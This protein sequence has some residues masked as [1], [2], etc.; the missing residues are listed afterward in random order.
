VNWW[1]NTSRRIL[2]YNS[3]SAFGL[4]LKFTVLTALVELA[5]ADYLAA[6]AVAVEIVILHNFVWHLRWTWRDRSFALSRRGVLFRF[7]LFQ[8]GAGAIAMT[9]NLVSM[10]LLVGSAGLHYLAAAVAATIVAGTANFLFSEFVVFLSPPR[11][12]NPANV[13]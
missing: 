6:T 11:G 10:R 1:L 3:V 2:K 7:C 4:P 9:S 5:G 12:V 13:P 8:C